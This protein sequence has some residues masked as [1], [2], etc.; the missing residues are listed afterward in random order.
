MILSKLL[1]SVGAV[2][3][4]LVK[5]KF[6]GTLTIEVNFSQGGIGKANVVQKTALNDVV[7]VSDRD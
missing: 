7:A 1:Q 3:T 6:T 4:D 2:L 5:R